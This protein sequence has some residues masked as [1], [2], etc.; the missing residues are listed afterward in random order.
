VWI[1]G[2]GVGIALSERGFPATPPA[3]HVARY[4]PPVKG[5]M[6]DLLKICAFPAVGTLFGLLSR[7]VIDRVTPGSRSASSVH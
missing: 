4:G 2:I 6:I 3:E 7:L 1:I 5:G